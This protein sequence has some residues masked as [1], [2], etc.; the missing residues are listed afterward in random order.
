[1][2]LGSA[3]IIENSRERMSNDMTIPLGTYSYTKGECVL[4]AK[5]FI[6][7]KDEKFWGYIN[8][9]TVKDGWMDIPETNCDD[10]IRPYCYNL[11]YGKNY[12]SLINQLKKFLPCD[13]DY[14]ELYNVDF[15]PDLKVVKNEA[16]FY[17]YS[18]N[19]EI[20]REFMENILT[21]QIALKNSEN[22]QRERE[23]RIKEYM[24][25]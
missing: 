3:E 19:E 12:H 22:S 24:G 20:K 23:E 5:I 14:F 13:C 9:Y 11:Y 18:K 15:D 16:K 21:P 6:K 8:Y 4:K 1:M 25:E 7:N 2:T 17:T 10:R